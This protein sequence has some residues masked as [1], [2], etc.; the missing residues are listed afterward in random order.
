MSDKSQTGYF[1]IER[2]LLPT[3]L[4][5]CLYKLKDDRQRIDF[6]LEHINTVYS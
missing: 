3:T 4:A 5:V 6:P 2:G 1:C